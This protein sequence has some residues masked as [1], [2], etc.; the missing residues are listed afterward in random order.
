MS[1]NETWKD[2]GGEAATVK[3]F[4]WTLTHGADTWTHN[5]AEIAALSDPAIIEGL[6]RER[7]VGTPRFSRVDRSPRGQP[8]GFRRLHRTGNKIEAAT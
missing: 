4:A 8:H 5:P 6:L 3:P 7:E 1:H 2:T